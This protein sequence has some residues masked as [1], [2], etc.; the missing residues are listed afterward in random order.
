MTNPQRLLRYYV[1]LFGLGGIDLLYYKYGTCYCQYA[2]NTLLWASK[3]CCCC[4]I[5]YTNYP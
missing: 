2:H 4:I 1:N 3:T 5:A